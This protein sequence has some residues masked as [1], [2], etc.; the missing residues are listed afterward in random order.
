[1]AKLALLHPLVLMLLTAVSHAGA[2]E[3]DGFRLEQLQDGFWRGDMV[4]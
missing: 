3:E 1:M 4:H 2:Q